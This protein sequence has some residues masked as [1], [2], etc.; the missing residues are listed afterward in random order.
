MKKKFWYGNLPTFKQINTLIH[1]AVIN[2]NCQNR[3]TISHFSFYTTVRISEVV[4]LLAKACSPNIAKSR[5]E[6]Q[7][8]A[9][10]RNT[11]WYVSGHE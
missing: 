9:I 6:T 7:T 4:E 3:K 8:L 2:S 5:K 1:K 11:I 10:L